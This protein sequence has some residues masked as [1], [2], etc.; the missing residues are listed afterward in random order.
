MGPVVNQQNELAEPRATSNS[1][2][3]SQASAP[4]PA[5]NSP[6]QQGGDS[7]KR[8]VGRRAGRSATREEIL[9]AARPMFAERGFAGTSIRA[10]AREAKVD[11][12]LVMHY[13]GDKE[14]LFR[15]ALEL[16]VNPREILSKVIEGDREKLPERIITT[17]LAVWEGPVTGEAMQAIVRRVFGEP[18]SFNLVRDFMGELIIESLS[19]ALKDVPED[20]ARTRISLVVSQMLGF[21]LGR[22]V[23]GLDSLQRMTQEEIVTYLEPTLRRYLLTDL[24]DLDTSA[25]ELS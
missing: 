1:E 16:P 13:F 7:G 6:E 9:N 4:P 12:A 24:G 18:D 10:I 17:F 25:G 8:R 19:P 21:V 2:S 23:V 15:S 20:E 11:P 5:A 14:G 22:Y 3:A